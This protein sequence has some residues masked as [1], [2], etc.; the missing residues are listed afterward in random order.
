MVAADD[1]LSSR[2]AIRDGNRA[3]VEALHALE[4]FR[5]FKQDFLSGA[6]TKSLL[7]LNLASDEWLDSL[8]TT[9]AN[10]LNWVLIESSIA[11][12]GIA[13]TLEMIR[14]SNDESQGS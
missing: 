12:V 3:L 6:H 4:R 7:R 10:L 5:S 11:H 13:E 1:V 2:Q 14:R 9:E 8:D